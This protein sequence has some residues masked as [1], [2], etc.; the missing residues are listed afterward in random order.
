MSAPPIAAET[1]SKAAM[2]GSF[3]MIAAILHQ[4]LLEHAD[5]IL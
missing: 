1:G 5:E 2:A 3:L 4:D